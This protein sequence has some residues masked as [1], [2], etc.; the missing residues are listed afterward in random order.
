MKL[1]FLNSVILK[2][3]RTKEECFKSFIKM[4]F[5]LL[6]LCS[7][8]V[9]Y[10][11]DIERFCADYNQTKNGVHMDSIVKMDGDILQF[12]TENINYNKDHRQTLAFHV[13]LNTRQYRMVMYKYVRLSTGTVIE[14][15]DRWD[16][17]PPWAPMNPYVSSALIYVSEN[18]DRYRKY[19][20]NGDW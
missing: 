18:L 8:S 6:L 13:N 12:V 2:I 3:V 4:L 16:N 10:A 9:T 14:E 1:C 20:W 11:G 17:P 7:V 5:P 19:G 15:G